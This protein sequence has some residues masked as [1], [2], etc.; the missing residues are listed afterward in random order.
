[1]QLQASSASIYEYDPIKVAPRRFSLTVIL[2]TD[3]LNSL[4]VHFVNFY[5]MTIMLFITLIR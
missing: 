5:Y 3:D 4:F 1:M 2:T